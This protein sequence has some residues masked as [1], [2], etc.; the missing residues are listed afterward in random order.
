MNNRTG[1]FTQRFERVIREARTQNRNI[2]IIALQ[3][4]GGG[5]F[6]VLDTAEKREKYTDSV[7]DFLVE[8]QHKTYHLKGGTIIPLRVDGYD[9]EYEW[10]FVDGQQVPGNQ[11]EMATTILTQIRSKVDVLGKT[12]SFQVSIT[13][14]SPENLNITPEDPKHLDKVPTLAEQL[15]Y[16]N[17]QNCSGGKGLGPTAYKEAIPGLKSSQILYGIDVEVPSERNEA[18]VQSLDSVLKKVQDNGPLGGVMVWR[19]NSDNWVFQNMLHAALLNRIHG[20]QSPHELEDRVKKGWKT[21][22]RNTLEKGGHPVSPW[23]EKDWLTAKGY[24]N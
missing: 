24:R 6:S 20:K 15:D 5:D 13:P 14:A 7:K 16:V 12:P 22:G 8:W 21:G 4:Y 17:M 19:L 18:D 1:I 3:F 10:D 2:K 11:T 9:V 23:I